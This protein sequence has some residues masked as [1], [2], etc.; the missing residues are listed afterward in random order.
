MIQSLKLKTRT[1]V[2][3]CGIANTNIKNFHGGDYSEWDE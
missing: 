2:L 1:E 3:V